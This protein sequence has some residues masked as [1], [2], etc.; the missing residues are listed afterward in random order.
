M[1]DRVQHALYG[2]GTV[3]DF[4]GTQCVVQ[5]DR[6]NGIPRRVWL[7]QLTFLDSFPTWNSNVV[8]GRF[9]GNVVDLAEYLRARRPTGPAAA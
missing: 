5:F 7:V 4:D 6:D 3:Q 2:T 1:T 8:H 9:G